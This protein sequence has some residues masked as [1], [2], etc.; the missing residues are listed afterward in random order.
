MTKEKGKG[1][2]LGFQAF[3]TNPEFKDQHDN[4]ISHDLGL[5]VDEDYRR[6]KTNLNIA[7]RIQDRLLTHLKQKTPFKTFSLGFL[8]ADYQG[9]S[10]SDAAQAFF[11]SQFLRYDRPGVEVVRGQTYKDDPSKLQY[12]NIFFRGYADGFKLLS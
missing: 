6:G 7:T 3:T 8:A 9:F 2:P 4:P 1:R 10:R 5:Y 12:M 11:K